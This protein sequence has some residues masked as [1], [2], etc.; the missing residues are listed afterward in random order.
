MK[1]YLIFY[2]TNKMQDTFYFFGYLLFD[3]NYTHAKLCL[4]MILFIFYLSLSF[5]L[6]IR[7]TLHVYCAINLVMLNLF[8]IL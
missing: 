5:I 1:V 6:L 2:N 8:M 3:A 7:L 4:R